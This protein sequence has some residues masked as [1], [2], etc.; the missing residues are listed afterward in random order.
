MS[1]YLE[2]E[3]GVTNR[4]ALT[5]GLPY[6]FAKYTDPDPPPPPIP[7]L[8]A[9]QCRC[10]HSG[11]QDLGL[12]AR[13]NLTNRAL[14]LT[15]SI[16]IGVP[17]HDYAFRG[18]A[19][20]GRSLREVRIGVDAG[21]RLDPISSN[22]SVQG[23]YSYAFVE[24]VLDVPNNRSNATVE[25]IYLVK[26]RLALRGLMSWQRTHGGLRF[27]SPPPSDLLFPGEV[28]TP[29]RLYQHDRL[30]RDNFFHAGGG[31]AYSFP[32]LDIF[33]TYRAFVSGTDTHAGGA[34][35]I[36][37]SVPFRLGGPHR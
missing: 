12:T 11:W 22:L 26:R 24:K 23:R 33:A 30:L 10:W 16:A 27:G 19:A 1:L 28:D 17:S 6:V 20:L 3:Y 15:P 5:A 29:E 32:Q 25:G 34:L 4:L 37:F 21:K 8:P 31:L 36:G 9:D 35:T 13:Y 14:L 18:E 7:F 2:A